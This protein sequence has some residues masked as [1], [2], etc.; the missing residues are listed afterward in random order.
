MS[1]HRDHF[2][3][4]SVKIAKARAKLT[5]ASDRLNC[6]Q[7]EMRQMQEEMINILS[8]YV[9]M[10]EDMF[11]VRMDIVCRTERGVQDVKTIQIK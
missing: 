6:N 2:I 11:E 8:K 9:D 3:R 7:D 5:I 1:L 10:S 4:T